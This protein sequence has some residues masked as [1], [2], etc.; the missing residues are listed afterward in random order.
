MF[1][2]NV[3]EK[4]KIHTMCSVT[5]FFSKNRA[6]Y[7]RML[8]NVV[9]QG[10]PQMTIWRMRFACWMSKAKKYTHTGCVIPF[11]VPLQQCLNERAS[12]LRYRYIACLV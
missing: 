11:A 9:E 12:T 1:Q 5:F 8:K 3:V 2:T 6:V 7:E 10:G 4:I